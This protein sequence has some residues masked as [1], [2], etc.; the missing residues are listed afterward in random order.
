M[1]GS[2]IDLASYQSFQAYLVSDTTNKRK[3]WS[4]CSR[5]ER[6]LIIGSYESQ[7][8]CKGDCTRTLILQI[9]SSNKFVYNVAWKNNGVNKVFLQMSKKTIFEVL[10][11]PVDND[12]YIPDRV[13]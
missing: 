6:P 5:R 10:Q 9:S 12:Q 7:K 2:I 1:F 11:L 4:I 13:S 3:M 8:G